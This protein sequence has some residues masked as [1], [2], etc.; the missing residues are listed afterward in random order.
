MT[1][2]ITRR[3]VIR[4]RKELDPQSL[5]IGRM[6][7]VIEGC[8]E[9]PLAPG[10]CCGRTGRTARTGTAQS[11]PR[12]L[13]SAKGRSFG[14]SYAEMTASST[15]WVWWIGFRAGLD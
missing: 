13:N 5:H 8:S 2:K 3:Q 10:R 7:L 12:S 15:G 9:D 1:W 14:L 11:T 4:P 6:D